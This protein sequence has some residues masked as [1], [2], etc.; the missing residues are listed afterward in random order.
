MNR[1]GY[2]AGFLDLRGQKR[3]WLLQHG[4]YHRGYDVF[5]FLKI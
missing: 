4:I 3:E 1:P 5:A 2:E